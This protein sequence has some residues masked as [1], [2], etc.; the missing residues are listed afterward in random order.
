MATLTLTLS[1]PGQ[2][3]DAGLD[4]FVRFHGWTEADGR[5]QL[6]FAEDHFRGHLREGVREWNAREAKRLAAAAATAQTAAA[7]DLATLTLTEG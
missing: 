6:A 5:T 3:I 4:S 2:V 7:L 1:G